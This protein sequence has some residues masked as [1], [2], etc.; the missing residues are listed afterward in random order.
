M[1]GPACPRRMRVDG[2]GHALLPRARLARDEHRRVAG[3]G[4]ADELPHGE[5]RGARSDEGVALRCS[6]GG[7]FGRAL[8]LARVGGPHERALAY[9]APHGVEQHGQVE[10]LGGVVEG[11]E[12]HRADGALAVAI[13][14][15]HDDRHVGRFAAAQRLQ[16]VD[17][18]AVLQAYVEQ[19]AV[20]G[21]GL[22]H[23]A[24]LR[25]PR[26]RDGLVARPAQHAHEPLTQGP[27]VVDHQHRRH[28]HA[29]CAAAARG[30]STTNTVRPPSRA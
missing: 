7:W 18:V 22:Q 27:L 10:G 8:G 16:E 26:R 25:E 12:A 21:L 9:S 5:H 17:A 11:A 20:D 1:K 4:A 19:H 3:G 15:R 24:G 2:A 29:S 6:A 23:R 13:G 14:R 28:A 30:S